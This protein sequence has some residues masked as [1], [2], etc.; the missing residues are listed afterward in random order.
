[1][2]D[3]KRSIREKINRLDFLIFSADQRIRDFENFLQE[4][5]IR[6]QV[7]EPIEKGRFFTL[8]WERYPDG[9]HL[10]VWY[11]GDEIYLLANESHSVRLAAAQTLPKLLAQIEA[12]LDH[13]LKEC[14]SQEAVRQVSSAGECRELIGRDAGGHLWD[15]PVAVL[16]PSGPVPGKKD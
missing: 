1:M 6:F 16:C 12:Y 14:E 15:T 7:G 10:G 4:V 8:Y 2:S 11:G 13:Q 3:I 9:W 5:G